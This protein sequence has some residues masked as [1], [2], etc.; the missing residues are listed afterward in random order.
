MGHTIVASWDYMYMLF[1]RPDPCSW[2]VL[3]AVWV[4]PRTSLAEA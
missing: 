2:L 4:R 1:G 3:A